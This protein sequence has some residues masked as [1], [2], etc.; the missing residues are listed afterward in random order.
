VKGKDPKIDKILEDRLKKT[1]QE[2]LNGGD[3]Q[4]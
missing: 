3:K 1:K 2:M 4:W